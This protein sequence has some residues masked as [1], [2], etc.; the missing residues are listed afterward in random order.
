MSAKVADLG[1]AR[2][3][4]HHATHRTTNSCGTMSHMAPELLRYG[5]LSPAV[6]IYAFGIM[7]WELYSQGQAAFDKL[8][9]GQFF[10]TVVLRKL[11]PCVPAGMPADYALVMC[12][13]WAADPAE[14]P[15]VSVLR[16]CLELMLQDRQHRVD[17]AAA[18]LAAAAAAPNA[19]DASGAR[20]SAAN[21]TA[22]AA[23]AL[24]PPG[25]DV[26]PALQALLPQQKQPRGPSPHGQQQAA[27]ASSDAAVAQLSN[28]TLSNVSLSVLFPDAGTPTGSDTVLF[29][30][31]EEAA[32]VCERAAAA[33]TAARPV[34]RPAVNRASPGPAVGS[35]LAGSDVEAQLDTSVHNNRVWF[36]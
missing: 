21:A 13:C 10:E 9:Y 14:R 20:G 16:A 2:C 34:V 18:V 27:G 5:R 19:A 1:L 32:G 11:R 28:S 26:L 8:H 30:G 25:M 17:A 7:M 12:Q 23:A 15:S 22:A 36:V 3:L 35:P 4:A 24:P 29:V 33:R 31:E 6:D